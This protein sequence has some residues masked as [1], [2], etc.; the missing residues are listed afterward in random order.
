MKMQQIP[1]VSLLLIAL[2]TQ[3]DPEEQSNQ[4]KRL[5]NI[6]FSVTNY[7]H[8]Q[9]NLLPYSNPVATLLTAFAAT[10]GSNPD[11]MTLE[12]ALKQPDRDHFIDAMVKELEDHTA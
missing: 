3:L 12:Q 1:T 8:L 6:H 2:L 4:H 5:K 11:T 7:C 10:T 9:A